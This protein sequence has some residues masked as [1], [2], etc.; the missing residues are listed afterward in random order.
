MQPALCFWLNFYM[1]LPQ[2]SCNNLFAQQQK[3]FCGENLQEESL[4][5][6]LCTLTRNLEAEL[7]NPLSYN[8]SLQSPGQGL[9]SALDFEMYG[10]VTQMH[11]NSTP[12]YISVMSL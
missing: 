11:R 3:N 7:Q 6:S 12:Q 4:L 9:H 10:E 5:D 2:I 8:T 1:S